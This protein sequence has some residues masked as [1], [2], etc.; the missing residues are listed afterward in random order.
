MR[1]PGKIRGGV[2]LVTEKLEQIRLEN[3]KQC[4][5]GVEAM[6]EVKVCEKCGNPSPLSKAYCRECGSKLP[7]KTLY[8]IYKERHNCCPVCDTV[9][10]DGMEYCPQCGTAIKKKPNT[11]IDYK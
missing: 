2:G 5:F 11:T 3:M 6:K 10:S 1:Q 9:L 4:G 8:D 7:D